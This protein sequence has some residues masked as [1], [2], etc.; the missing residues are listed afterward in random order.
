[1]AE[2]S[3]TAT[4]PCESRHDLI[5]ELHAAGVDNALIMRVYA[6]IETDRAETI[7]KAARLFY[8]QTDD[9]HRPMTL[10]EFSDEF[11]NMS[12]RLW[13]VTAAV[14]DFL[15]ATSDPVGSGVLQLVNDVAREM[16]RLT[17]AFTAESW[18]GRKQEARS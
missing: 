2:E 18:L 12:R 17:E 7:A 4:A 3:N 11:N 16:E 1:M 5:G 15:G 10:G 6:C 13:G 8:R 14:D 9:E